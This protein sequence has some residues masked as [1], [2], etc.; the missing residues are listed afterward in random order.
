M[1]KL[2]MPLRANRPDIAAGLQEM[3]ELLAKMAP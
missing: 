3:K 1:R 2:A